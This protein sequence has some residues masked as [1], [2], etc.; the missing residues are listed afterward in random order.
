MYLFVALKTLAQ[1]RGVIC[2]FRDRAAF[3]AAAVHNLKGL[4]DRV[5]FHVTT[6]TISKFILSQ[7]PFLCWL[8]ELNRAK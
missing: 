6:K 3:Y 5:A 8:L 4:I 7:T 2:I 1:L